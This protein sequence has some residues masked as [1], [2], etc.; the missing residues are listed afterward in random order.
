MGSTMSVRTL[1]V[2]TLAVATG[3]I[4]VS[5]FA[6]DSASGDGLMGMCLKHDAWGGR[7]DT[8]AICECIDDKS[9]GNKRARAALLAALKN[10]DDIA[11]GSAADEIVNS[12]LQRSQ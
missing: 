6:D 10:G 2:A 12:C 5:A 11:Q 8:H 4:A 1:V 7:V 9:G 3:S